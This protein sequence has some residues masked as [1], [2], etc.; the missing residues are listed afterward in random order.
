MGHPSDIVPEFTKGGA[1]LGSVGYA[2]L[3][4]LFVAVFI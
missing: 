4:I 3:I 1:V 2:L